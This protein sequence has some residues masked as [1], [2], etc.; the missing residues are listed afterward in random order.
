MI[1]EQLNALKAKGNFS[2]Q[3]LSNLTGIPVP[4]IRKT[5]S[6]ETANPSYDV[7]NKL[8]TAMRRAIPGS[9]ENK[10]ELI[11]Q[12]EGDEDMQ[13]MMEQMKLLYEARISDL[14]RMID[15]LTAERKTL[16][17]T[18]ITLVGILVAFISYLFV[19]GMHGNWGFFRY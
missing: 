7:V 6:G 8:L 17:I 5:F 9:E 14:W 4:T 10:E 2:W 1:I 16:F 13:A 15:K 19:D 11:S 3:E 12:S 18:M